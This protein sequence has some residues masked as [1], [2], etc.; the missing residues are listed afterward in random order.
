M[1]KK[2]LITLG[3]ILTLSSSALSFDDFD[4]DDYKDNN[5][6]IVKLRGFGTFGDGKQKKLPEPTSDRGKNDPKSVQKLIEKSIGLE[7]AASFFFND[8]FAAEFSLGASNYRKK[9]Q[10]AIAHNY[11]EDKEVTGNPNVYAFPMA[12]IAQYH[13]APYGAISPYVGVGYGFTKLWSRSPEIQLKNLHGAVVQ[14]GIDFV[15]RDDTIINL[16]VKKFMGSTK[17]KYKR[18]VDTPVSSNIKLSPIM[19]SLGV[20]YKF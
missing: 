15:M 11:S 7:G 1:I 10:A 5:K 12:A 3:T 16:D 9:K 4:F 14:A 13:V 8:F 19:V 17:A 18:I 2:Q 6:M 20:G